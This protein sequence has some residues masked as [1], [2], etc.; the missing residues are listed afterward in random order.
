MYR[1]LLALLNTNSELK[2]QTLH[3]IFNEIQDNYTSTLNQFYEEA[4]QSTLASLDLT[5]AINFN[6]ELFT[7]NKAMLMAVKDFLLNEDRAHQFNHI[8]YQS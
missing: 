2:E 3:K 6:R 5:T 4:Q 1:E 8:E 7:S